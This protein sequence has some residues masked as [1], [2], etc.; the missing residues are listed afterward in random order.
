MATRNGLPAPRQQFVRAGRHNLK[1]G[2]WLL[3]AGNKAVHRVL[4]TDAEGLM[5]TTSTGP[6]VVSW[7]DIEA[8]VWKVQDAG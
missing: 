2:D 6:L 7:R 5:L 1:P 3:N 4:E 8:T